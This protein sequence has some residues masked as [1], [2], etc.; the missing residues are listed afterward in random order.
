MILL[1]LT[2]IQMHIKNCY[3]T[4]WKTSI[5]ILYAYYRFLHLLCAEALI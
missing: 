4:S 3:N 2:M 1:L 5:S